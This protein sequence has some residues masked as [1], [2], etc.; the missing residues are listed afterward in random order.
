MKLSPTVKLYIGLV[1]LIAVFAIVFAIPDVLPL[2]KQPEF[3][4]IWIILLFLN[5]ISQ[6]YEIELI[7]HRM[8]STAISICLAAV[9]LGQTPLTVVVALLGTLL[10]EI[11]LRWGRLAESLMSFVYRVFFNTSQAVLSAF[12]AAQIFQFLGGN[13]LL[14]FVNVS[15]PETI[16]Q[17]SIASHVLPALG[18]FVTYVLINTASVSGILSLTQG[19]SFTYHLKFSLRYLPVQIISLWVLGVLIAI[20]YAQ[21]PLNLLLVLLL[22]GLVHVSLR[23]YMKLRHEA[24]KTFHRVSEMLDARDHYTYEHS[25]GVADLAEKIAR[26]LKLDQEHI[27]QIKSAAVIHDIGK[28]AVPDQILRKPGPLTEEEWLIIKQHPDTGA[29]LLRD[30]EIYRDIV[31]IVRHEHEHWDGSG[32]PKGLKGEEIPIGARIVAAADI[33]HALT[34]DRPYRPAYSHEGAL[35]IIIRGMSGVVLDPQVVDALI[36]VLKRRL[37]NPAQSPRKAPTN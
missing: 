4:Q 26:T 21:S 16:P 11:V 18:A 8:T 23:N 30:L 15:Q 36:S 19:T 34:T 27:E 6:V 13:R 22:L 3:V 9:I 12:F 24:T 31:D 32:Y 28:V 7:H 20:V 10:A 25:Q 33:Y 2:F 29:E 17:L 37:E 5:F 35:H 1:T 14:D